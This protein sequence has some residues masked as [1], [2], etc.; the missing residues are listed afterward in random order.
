MVC[1]VAFILYAGQYWSNINRL[2]F[3]V[4][5]YSY[6]NYGVFKLPLDGQFPVPKDRS[7]F[8]SNTLVTREGTFIQM[9]CSHR[10]NDYR[11]IGK[12]SDELIDITNNAVV[13]FETSLHTAHDCNIQILRQR[14]MMGKF[15]LL[16]LGSPKIYWSNFYSRDCTP[17]VLANLAFR[18]KII[19]KGKYRNFVPSGL[20][21]NVA[22]EIDKKIALE[23]LIYQGKIF[24]DDYRPPMQRVLTWYQGHIH[25]FERTS[26]NS[27]IPFTTLGT[28]NK[29]G[30]LIY[31]YMLHNFKTFALLHLRFDTYLKASRKKFFL[32]NPNSEE[33]DYLDNV[34]SQRSIAQE[35]IRFRSLDRLRP[36]NIS[37]Y[38]SGRE[39]IHNEEDEMPDVEGLEFYLPNRRPGSIL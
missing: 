19:V 4:N 22:I 3:A 26:S 15:H 1:A 38:I 33:W 14:N 27:W 34:D 18:G 36:I 24:M 32:Q 23:D 16:R 39:L 13:S 9:Y 21:A 6:P 25:I 11:I 17:K 10:W 20:K 30:D 7:V 8:M 29:N 37:G 5:H 2:V 35:N 31:D 12:I 28:E